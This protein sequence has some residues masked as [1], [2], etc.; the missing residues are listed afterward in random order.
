[1]SINNTDIQFKRSVNDVG[2]LGGVELSFGEP[3]FVDN[4][5]HD[6]EG[7]LTEPVNAYIYVGRKSDDEGSNT[8]TDV[9]TAAKSPVIKALSF[10]K[11]NSLVFYDEDRN[12]II[13]ESGELLPVTQ[14][15]ANAITISD[16]TPDASASKY[17]ILCQPA[18][19][20]NVCK[21]SLEDLGISINGNG[22]MTGA[23]WN[24]YAE[25]RTL[26]GDAEPG[27]IVCDSGDGF[28]EL[29]NERLQPCAH[30]VSDT[31]GHLIGKKKDDAVPIAVSGRALVKTQEQFLEIGDCLCAG[32]N[33][34]AYKMTRQ[35]IINY[36]DRI[37]GIVCELP[38][39]TDRVWV[40]IK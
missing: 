33:G 39:D 22:V 37:V 40:N 5:T 23:A 38:Q 32:P 24:D 1:M 21:F 29:S 19:T 4:T 34:M 27:Q 3:F 7:S 18:G 35:E 16:L 26:H 2:V 20:D 13:N 28:M 14:L 25:L 15:R 6:T 17:H 10:S 8:A 11:A 31:Y 12:T 30:I 9:V 36:P